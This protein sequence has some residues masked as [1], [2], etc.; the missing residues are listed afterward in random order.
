MEQIEYS[1]TSANINQTPG[2]HPKDSTLNIKHGESLKARKLSGCCAGSVDF[3]QS[4]G[5]QYES[6]NPLSGVTLGFF[7]QKISAKSVTNT[8]KD[9]TKTLWLWKSGTKASEPQV[10]RQTIAGQ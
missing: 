3:V 4:Y 5:M 1:E 9:F 2:K 6:E 8:V 7:S 10:C